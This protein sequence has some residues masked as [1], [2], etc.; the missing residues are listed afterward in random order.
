[1]RA[2]VIQI[3]QIREA[4]RRREVDLVVSP[5]LPGFVL[6]L[7]GEFDGY[8]DFFSILAS[9]VDYVEVAGGIPIGDLVLLSDLGELA[10]F[11]KNWHWLRDRYS[12]Q[13]L[14]LRSADSADWANASH[15]DTFILVA[16]TI[17]CYAG[18]DWA[19]LQ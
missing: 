17:V 8:G 4:C 11:T 14:I 7:H 19:A 13:A 16:S 9:D 15:A 1:M 5:P 6:S 12:G 2:E 3:T 18:R 10:R